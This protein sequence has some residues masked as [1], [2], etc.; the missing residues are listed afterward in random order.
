MD[1]NKS[2]SSVKSSEMNVFVMKFNQNPQ[3]IAKLKLKTLYFAMFC[4]LFSLWTLRKYPNNKISNDVFF[5]GLLPYLEVN[6]RRFPARSEFPSMVR[7]LSSGYVP[8]MAFGNVRRPFRALNMR[9]CAVRLFA[10]RQIRVR[11]S[12][13]SRAHVTLSPRPNA[14]FIERTC[15]KRTVLFWLIVNVIS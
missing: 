4:D 5:C 8:Y 12:D 14:L 13:W 7:S 6:S 1:T 2:K 15:H 9:A 11:R 3:E 10:A